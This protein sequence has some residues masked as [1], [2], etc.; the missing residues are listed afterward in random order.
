MRALGVEAF[1]LEVDVTVEAT[2]VAAIE[3][4][5][6]RL[7]HMDIMVNNAGVTSPGA[8]LHQ[9]DW[10]IWDDIFS[11][12]LKG[13][14]FGMKHMLPHMISRGYGRIINTAS[15]L[16]HKPTGNHGAYCASKAAV[17]AL[18]ASV[19]QEVAAYGVTVNCVCPGMTRTAMLFAG[20]SEFVHEK[21]KALPIGRAAEAAEI[22]GAY[23][24]LAS[25]SASFVIGQ[26]L[27][28]TA[29]T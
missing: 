9:Q 25:D 15:Q 2:I 5:L 10:R 23:V 18:S 27:S 19:A 6:A 21:L 24:Y 8:P 1:A 14:A 11:V 7:G 16:A 12:N 13:V 3:T 17:V 29:A 26:S 22:A 20:G 4:S 28:P